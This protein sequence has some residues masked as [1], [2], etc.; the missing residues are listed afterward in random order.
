[1]GTLEYFTFNGACFELTRVDKVKRLRYTDN[2]GNKTV[3]QDTDTQEIAD[4]LVDE[5]RRYN[6][7]MLL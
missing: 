2:N 4:K 5:F 7:A 6:A 3:L 1:M